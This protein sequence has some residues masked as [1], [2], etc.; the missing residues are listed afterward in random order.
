MQVATSRER[1]DVL[2]EQLKGLHATSVDAIFK[3]TAA[4]LI[5]AGWVVTSDSAR[6]F[7]ASDSMVRWISVAA[8]ALYSAVF[9]IAGFSTCRRSQFIGGLLKEEA[10]MPADFY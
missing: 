5:A 9:S 2:Y 3:A 4:F 7:L 10:Y 8:L 1:F 6:A